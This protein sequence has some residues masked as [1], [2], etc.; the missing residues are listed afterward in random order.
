MN[1]KKNN[2]LK[3]GA[4]PCCFNHAVHLTGLLKYQ[5]KN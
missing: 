1:E 3:T 5:F 2:H 4:W